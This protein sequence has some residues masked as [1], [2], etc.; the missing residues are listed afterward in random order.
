MEASSVPL[1]GRKVS[2]V[3]SQIAIKSHPG[4]YNTIDAACKKELAPH[5]PWNKGLEKP[6]K[7]YQEATDVE[8]QKKWSPFA[9]PISYWSRHLLLSLHLL[10][11]SD[12]H[13]LEKAE[14]HKLQH[15]S[16]KQ[17]MLA[18]HALLSIVLSTC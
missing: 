1:Q 4:L 17:D 16:T 11:K 13:D 2:F 14:S 9:G 5:P 12:Q 18:E 6:K 15:Q 10:V 7:H 3:R 8:A